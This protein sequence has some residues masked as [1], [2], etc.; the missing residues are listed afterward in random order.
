M[1]YEAEVLA[2]LEEAER[3]M[4]KMEGRNAQKEEEEIPVSEEPEFHIEE[5]EHTR[6][7]EGIQFSPPVIYI[8]FNVI[9]D[10]NK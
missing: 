7:L 10:H 1:Q 8:F 3:R 9:N 5:A 6:W 4:A 2:R